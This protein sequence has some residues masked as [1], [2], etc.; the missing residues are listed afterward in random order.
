M[1]T[2]SQKIKNVLER[3]VVDVIDRNDLE[4]RMLTGEKLRIKL[5]IDPTS[6]DLHI[7]HG[8]TIKKLKEFQ[9]L[10][11]QIVLI[12]GDGTALIGDTSDKASGREVLSQ[13]Q[14]DINKEKYLEQVGKVLN[15]EEVEVRHNGEW[16]NEFD[17]GKWI[18]LASLFTLQQMIER[19]NYAERIKNGDPVGLHEALYPLLQGYDSVAVK[20]DVEIGG[21]DQL[22]NLLAGRKIQKHHKQDEQDILTLSLLAGTDGRKMSKSWGNVIMINDTPEDKFGKVMRVPDQLI[23]VYM[24]SATEIPMERVREVEQV[25]ENEDGNPIEYK[26]ELAHALVELYDG[27]ESAEK[28]Q[29]HFENTIQG[30][31]TPQDVP[32]IEVSAGELELKEFLSLLIKANLI[33]SKSEGMRLIGE[34]AVSID[35]EVLKEEKVSL[36]K[37]VTVKVGKRRFLNIIVK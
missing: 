10:G 34:G 7:G 9:D 13:E 1:D 3:G 25:M 11:H 31:E 26:K 21:T 29:A 27:K 28:A 33:K 20:A 15:L 18:Q 14:I 36:S 35:G 2:D 19:E 12:I 32:S 5:G 8:S 4:K 23:P 17:T 24:E 6:P 30:G 16:I 22:F 37:S